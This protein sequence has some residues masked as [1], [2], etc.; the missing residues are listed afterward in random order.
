MNVVYVCCTNVVCELYVLFFIRA[1]V[2]VRGGGRAYIEVLCVLCVSCVACVACVTRTLLML[3][4]IYV[5]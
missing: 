1:G 5:V 3:R 4:R 2:R